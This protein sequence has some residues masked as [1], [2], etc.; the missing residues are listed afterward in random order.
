MR[1]CGAPRPAEEWVCPGC[2]NTNF[3]GRMF[4]NMRKCGLPRPGM[5]TVEV[6]AGALATPEGSWKCLGC[7]NINYPT[8]TSCNARNCG[9]PRE[10]V[11]GGAVT[12]SHPHPTLASLAGLGT[13]AAMSALN[14]GG[15]GTYAGHPTLAQYAPHT[16]G[17]NK[18]NSVVSTKPVPAGSWIC[19]E[20]SNVNFPNR[21]TCNAKLCGKPRAEVDGGPPPAGMQQGLD[22]ENI[23]PQINNA[24]HMMPSAQAIQMQQ[25]FQAQATGGKAVP[26]GSWMC[27]KC[28]NVNFPT[29]DVCNARNCGTPRTEC[30]AG[31]APASGMQMQM[32][33]AQASMMQQMASPAAKMMNGASK[34]PPEGSWMCISCSNV[35]YPTRDTCNA[36]NCGLQRAE[37]DG[38]PPPPSATG[39]RSVS[40][41][42]NDHS[43]KAGVNNAMLEG[44]WICPHCQNE[45]YPT[46]TVCNM[47]SCGQPRPADV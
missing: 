1:T 13:L 45:N 22:R 42:S 29:R 7:G 47:R 17:M 39:A 32:P 34:P 8:R 28:N 14:G 12:G 23:M 33:L 38:G 46:R 2:N 16:A 3:A 4:C 20:C 41:L 27:S 30:D 21:D 35:N 11:D 5:H 9:R 43:F 25:A 19:I 37:C 40:P 18:V 10:E 44:S 24:N 6:K 26:A 31:P 36:K 15:V